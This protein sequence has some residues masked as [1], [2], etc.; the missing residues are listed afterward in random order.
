M[1]DNE[2]VII[3]AESSDHDRV[4]PMSCLQNI[5]HKINICMKKRTRIFM[6]GVMEWR[7]N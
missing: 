6:F 2:N 5:V 7:H 3:V 1:L 4:V